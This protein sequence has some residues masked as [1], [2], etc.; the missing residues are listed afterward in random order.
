MLT[1]LAVKNFFKKAWKFVVDQWLFFLAAVLGVLGFIAGTRGNNVK[2]VLDL[3]RQAEEDERAA[4]QDAR[5]RTEEIMNL[6]NEKMSSLNDEQ[7][8]AVGKIIREHGEDFEKEILRN[9]DKPLDDVVNELAEKYG[10]DRV[11]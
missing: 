4:R 1:W 7:R 2:E 3:R 9:R 6:L 10:L 11:G 8:D 5:A